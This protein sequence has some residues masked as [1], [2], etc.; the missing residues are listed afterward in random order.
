M[1]LVF[2]EHHTLPKR[3]KHLANAY[4]CII[5]KC[6]SICKCFVKNILKTGGFLLWEHQRKEEMEKEPYLNEK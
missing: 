5:Y 1:C 6:V 2:A 3:Y 4:I